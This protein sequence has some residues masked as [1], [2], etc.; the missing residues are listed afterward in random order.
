M[1]SNPS[2]FHV[3]PAVTPFFGAC[4]EPDGSIGLGCLSQWWQAPFFE[5]GHRFQTAEHFMMWCKAI[6]FG[7]AE[8]ARQIL[9]TQSPKEAK[10]LGRKVAG[11]DA[12]VWDAHS[13]AVVLAGNMAKFTHH[14]ELAEVLL[15]TGDT[16]LVEASPYDRIWGAGIAADDPRIHDTSQWLGQNRLGIA[17]MDVRAALRAQR[18]AT[19]P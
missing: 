15:D 2:P 1:S 14:P 18:A 11:F 4:Y 7:D 12:D 6:I 8:V 17:L 10:A 13:Q 19:Q 9:Q 5:Q 16:L 3:A